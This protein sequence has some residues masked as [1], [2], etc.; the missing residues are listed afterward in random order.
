MTPDVQTPPP[1][2]DCARV[3]EYAVLDESVSYSGRTLLFVDGKELGRVPCL[4]ICEDKKLRGVMLF[5]CNRE[6]TVLGCSGHGSV[7]EA[8]DRAEGIY[9][10]LS[11]C[12]VEAHVSEEEAER[13]LDELF[14][15]N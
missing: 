10:R 9:P 6:W 12:W 5:H 1:V 11:S 2:L 4:A 13:Y 7:S 15:G 8:K 14:G 3:I